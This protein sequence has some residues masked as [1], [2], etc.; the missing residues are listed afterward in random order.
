MGSIIG[1]NDGSVHLVAL[2]SSVVD[3][4]NGICLRLTPLA[5]GHKAR[6]VADGNTQKFGV[7]Y[8]RIFATVI[9]S[10][11]IRLVLILAAARDYNLTQIDIRQAYLQAKL[12]EKLMRSFTCVSRQAS[13]L[14]MNRAAHSCAA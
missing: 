8:D 11:T 12:H 9:K 5:G 3:T 7:D 4:A 1:L 13:P 2:K 6:L 14:S 10:T